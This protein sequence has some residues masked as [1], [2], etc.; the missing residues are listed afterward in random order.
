MPYSILGLASVGALDQGSHSLGRG[1]YVVG[2]APSQIGS[3]CEPLQGRT[4]ST[5]TSDRSISVQWATIPVL[6]CGETVCIARCSTRQAC[7]SR[8]PREPIGETGQFGQ[9]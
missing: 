2:L 1:G 8:A 5:A 4:G 9:E 6:R 7:L 3:R